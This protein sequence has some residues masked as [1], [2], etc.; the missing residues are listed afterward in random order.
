[1]TL[2]TAKRLMALFLCTTLLFAGLFA[3]QLTG[4]GVPS[5]AAPSETEGEKQEGASPNL[6]EQPEGNYTDGMKIPTRTVLDQEVKE[7]ERSGDHPGS[8]YFCNIDFYNAK[9]TETLLLLPSFRTYQQTSQD[10]VK[11]KRQKKVN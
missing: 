4:A 9:P 3:W 5:Y 1:M 6:V 10:M 8:P 2:T 7:R 11:G